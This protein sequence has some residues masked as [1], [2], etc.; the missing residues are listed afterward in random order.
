MPKRKA[1]DKYDRLMRNL[2]KIEKKN[3]KNVVFNSDSETATPPL[4]VEE[5]TD[6][7]TEEV[8]EVIEPQVDLTNTDTV[9]TQG[10]QNVIS[11]ELNEQLDLDILETLGE[12]PSS[13]VKYGSEI[14]KE[15]VCR[16]QHITTAGN[17]HFKQGMQKRTFRQ[18]FY[19]CQLYRY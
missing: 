18:K 9:Q 16:L 2:K 10:D 4:L 13:D 19:S 8:P 14:R 3:R 6:L 12:D 1:S 15:L 5:C 7:H 17:L 11:D